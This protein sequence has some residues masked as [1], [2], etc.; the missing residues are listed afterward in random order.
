[1]QDNAPYHSAKS[2]NTFLSGVDASV[3]EWPARRSD[4][5]P[6]ENV[7]NLL[8]EIDKEKNKRI[9]EQLERRMG[10]NIR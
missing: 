1:M 2:V 7:W 8:N 5:N 9:M 10:E 6:I 3:M 4:M